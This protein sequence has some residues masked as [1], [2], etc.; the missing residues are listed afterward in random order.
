MRWG[1]PRIPGGDLTFRVEQVKGNC[2]VGRR[3]NACVMVV[4]VV[5]VGFYAMVTISTSFIDK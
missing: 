5:V 2:D 3:E 4:V 1:C